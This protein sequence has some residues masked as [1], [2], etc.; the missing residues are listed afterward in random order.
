[1]SDDD[2][3]DSVSDP[4]VSDVDEAEMA[5]LM[6]DLDDMDD[7]LFKSDK[8]N[9][10]A[11]GS[12]KKTGAKSG[13]QNVISEKKNKEVSSKN[14][15]KFDEDDEDW[16]AADDL[17][18][19]D[20]DKKQP[21][22]RRQTIGTKKESEA[23]NS[24]ESKIN[25]DANKF[26]SKKKLMDDLFTDSSPKMENSKSPA[27]PV[28][29]KKDKSKLMDDLFGD[30]SPSK[31]SP[32]KLLPQS[33]NVIESKEQSI[34][35]KKKDEIS[36]D[37]DNDLFGGSGDAKTKSRSATSPKKSG[38]FMDSLLSKP[39]PSLT[40]HK[41]K[42]T[43]FVLDEKY[44]AMT[45]KE[46]PKK[47]DDMLFG[48]Y[49]SSLDKS[50]SSRKRTPKKSNIETDPF[51]FNPGPRR[52]GEPYNK[53][54]VVDDDDILGNLKSRRSKIK[55]QDSEFSPQREEGESRKPSGN[56]LNDKNDISPQK[57]LSQ[58]PQKSKNDDWLY[59]DSTVKTSNVKK[60]IGENN[61]SASIERKNSYIEKD[62]PNESRDWLG[63]M[64]SANKTPLK[65]KEE[66]S[67]IHKSHNSKYNT[68]ISDQITSPQKN[69]QQIQKGQDMAQQVENYLNTSIVNP[70]SNHMNQK[71][72]R[73][74]PA[75]PGSSD[76]LIESNQNVSPSVN[77]ELKSNLQQNS[78][79]HQIEANAMISQMTKQQQ[80]I[81]AEMAQ[82]QQQFQLEQQKL[83]QEAMKQQH[84]AKMKQY[85]EALSS[86]SNTM[87]QNTPPLKDSSIATSN[88]EEMKNIQV[89]LRNA[90]CEVAQLREKLELVCQQ[91][92]DEVKLLEETHHRKM[93]LEKGVWDRMEER[94]K[95]ESSSL[96]SD[97]QKKIYA[98]EE[99]R[100]KIISSHEISLSNV[101]EEWGGALKTTKQ[102]YSGLIDQMKEE[103]NVSL[104]RITELKDLELKAI[105]TS[106]GHAKDVEIVMGQLENNTSTISN[107][108][109]VL[110]ERHEGTQELAQRALKIKEK[111][112]QDYEAQLSASRAEAESE[113]ARLTALVHRLENTL[114]RQGSEV[115]GDR[116]RLAQERMKI[117]VEKN[118]IAEERRHLQINLEADRQNLVG[119]QENL[120]VEQR[121]LLK[122][123]AQKKQEATNF[124]NSV[125]NSSR[126]MGGFT[127][128]ADILALEEENIQLK[129][130]LAELQLVNQSLEVER[131][132]I[133]E[134]KI[135][136][137]EEMAAIKLEKDL[138]IQ[139]RQSLSDSVG[140]LNTQQSEFDLQKRQLQERLSEIARKTQAL[141]NEQDLIIKERHK[142]ESVREMQVNNGQGLC[143]SC[144]LIS[145]GVESV[146]LIASYSERV[147]NAGIKR[148]TSQINLHTNIKAN[149]SPS[150]VMSRLA[151]ARVK[152]N[153]EYERR[154][155]EISSLETY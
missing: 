90:E 26:E 88:D 135:K 3:F 146:N 123:V 99:E 31:K 7:D 73:S 38:G 13:K 131:D 61:V 147:S 22:K 34:Q 58:K 112:L 100:Q 140:E 129:K 68:Q 103:H 151:A 113:R 39:S 29:S 76:I 57:E 23:S 67:P 46:Q 127:I 89:S 137:E 15:V 145:G 12:N 69:I 50:N 49:E 111:Q 154:L 97:F 1:M 93:D 66:S 9:P 133:E 126:M 48:N 36:F 132:N 27:K 82:Q 101:K 37:D 95:A 120:L 52:R 5:K 80:Q 85:Q 20:D 83:M 138:I 74:S 116:W 142:L 81:E 55:N 54:F 128:N 136:L 30:S 87:L 117:E 119:A 75:R 104:K 155:Q 110:Q 24:T 62:V 11:T 130:R 32:E 53:P 125:N 64:L 6:A 72:N 77:F 28:E 139:E 84:E 35:K 148:P 40:P 94:L 149:L 60:E 91:H 150:A 4:P 122:M 106:S 107:I 143:P 78:S 105:M 70:N 18:G 21:V 108:T 65:F 8:K 51:D 109:A 79:Q 102:L 134:I 71:E 17:L 141:H 25:N 86:M 56:R 114:V 41:P 96:Y 153:Q 2:L 152:E 42:G 45:K 92:K 124:N 10:N 43:E 121:S 47:E 118:S 115:E 144:K 63:N 44:K 16:D 98:L 19:S 33:S 14:K 59:G